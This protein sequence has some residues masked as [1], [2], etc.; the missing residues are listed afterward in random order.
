MKKLTS[1]A[2]IFMLMLLPA[3]PAEAQKP[4]EGIMDLTF[5]LD[6]PGPQEEIPDWFGS[7]TIHDEVYPMAFFNIGTGKRFGPFDQPGTAHNG[8]V[9]FFGEI[10][11]IYA[12]DSTTFDFDTGDFV[13]G[14]V[15]LVGTDEGVVTIANSTYRMNGRVT[16]ANAPFENRQ[17]RNVHM[18]GIIV[19]H[20]FG[21]PNFGP[22]TLR[23]N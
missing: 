17:G 1:L 12:D 14:P 11:K 13:E 4:L 3:I 18:S 19:W 22:G 8:H 16:E 9:V 15:L 2:M 6:W 23:I 7:I 21:A 10:W 20:S 5:Y